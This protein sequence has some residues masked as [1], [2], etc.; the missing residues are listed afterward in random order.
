MSMA[1]TH[2]NTYNPVPSLCFIRLLS[3]IQRTE[4]SYSEC[5]TFSSFP[6]L[7]L[8]VFGGSSPSAKNISSGLLISFTIVYYR[9]VRSPASSI[10]DITGPA[11]PIFILCNPN[12]SSCSFFYWSLRPVPCILPIIPRKHLYLQN[13]ASL[14]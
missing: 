5:L 10:H 14:L 11:D 13:K 9:T 3:S 12:F 1:W 6:I 8:L 7:N 2:L 4:A